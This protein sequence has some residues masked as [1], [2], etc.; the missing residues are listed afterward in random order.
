MHEHLLEMTLIGEAGVGGIRGKAT[1]FTAVAASKHH[2]AVLYN[3]A[4]FGARRR[5]RAGFDSITHLSIYQ[6]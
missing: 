5:R 3:K 6:R 2:A 1:G 4:A